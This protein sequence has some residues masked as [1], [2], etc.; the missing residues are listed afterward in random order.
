[1]KTRKP[2]M[3]W[4]ECLI[5]VRERIK[6]GRS[7]YICF[8]IQYTLEDAGC[9][10]LIREYQRRVEAQLGQFSSY[11]SWLLHHHPGVYRK[12]KFGEKRLQPGRLA[13]IDN[14]IKLEKE[15]LSK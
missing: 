15:R 12:E 3:T 10:R 8:A 13:W 4:L 1:M 5:R 11:S 6:D 2:H 9:C 14:M 7:H